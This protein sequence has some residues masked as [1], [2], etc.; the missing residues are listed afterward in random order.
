[1]AYYKLDYQ[2]FD[3]KKEPTL[4]FK[5][6]TDN[7]TNIYG[8]D[9]VKNIEIVYDGD[10]EIMAVSSDSSIVSVQIS[11]KTLTITYIKSGTASITVHT[12]KT[13]KYKEAEII[14]TVTTIK[15]DPELEASDYSLT[16]MGATGS[17]SFTFNTISDGTVTATS[18][19][20]N[21]V[22]A[23]ISGSTVTATY[24]GAGTTN[25]NLVIAA[26]ERFNGGNRI[27]S[28]SCK[29]STPTLTLSTYSLSIDGATGSGTF[30]FNYTEGGDGTVTVSS[31]DPN[32]ATA[33]VNVTTITVVYV[34]QGTAT[35]TVSLSAGVKY[36][37]VSST[38]SV[39]TTRTNR[40]MSVSVTS[41]SLTGTS[42]TGALTVSFSGDDYLNYASTD[43][44]VA[45]VSVNQRISPATVAITRTGNGTCYIGFTLPQTNKWNAASGSCYVSCSQGYITWY[46][47]VYTW[48]RWQFSTPWNT[49]FASLPVTYVDPFNTY[50]KS[51]GGRI[52][53]S[54]D[55]TELY[56]LIPSNV[57]ARVKTGGWE[58]GYGYGQLH[59][60]SR[61]GAIVTPST[62]PTNGAVYYT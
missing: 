61:S 53:I 19:D 13:L 46:V 31:S 7:K 23:S 33:S 21:I 4:Y 48:G 29:K 24:V 37:A 47:E 32:V 39:T 22:T 35:I 54:G 28:I 25:I 52:G 17:G 44:N 38:C 2:Q 3:S 49:S 18:S 62:V 42:P 60:G 8:K 20:E 11:G 59:S 55:T 5:D 14:L 58:E 10:G 57:Y 27:I 36:E 1:M 34:S 16:I 41:M 56:I 12:S 50:A 26:T 6:I 30:T 43:G 15:S 51:V 40:T 9:I 45:V